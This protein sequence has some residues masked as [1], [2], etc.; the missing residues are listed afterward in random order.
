MNDSKINSDFKRTFLRERS[1]FAFQNPGRDWKTSKRPLGDGI[2]RKH[3]DHKL[4]IGTRAGW[5]V[6]F[7]CLDI[8]TPDK[9]ILDEVCSYF[10]F[11]DMN[12]LI[13]QSPNKGYH[14]LFKPRFNDRVPTQKLYYEC[15]TK[16]EKRLQQLL[17]I[18]QLEIF[19]KSN[20][21]LRGPLGR[22]QIFIDPDSFTPYRLNQEQLMNAFEKL[23]QTDLKELSIQRYIPFDYKEEPRKEE[24]LYNEKATGEYLYNFGPQPGITRYDT[25]WKIILYL[26]R[27]NFN[28]DEIYGKIYQYIIKHQNWFNE[29][30]RHGRQ[31]F[32]RAAAQIKYLRNNEAKYTSYPDFINNAEFYF[33]KSDLVWLLK[34]FNRK[35]EQRAM[36]NLIRYYRPR[37]QRVGSWVRIHH[38]RWIEWTDWRSYKRF[39]RMLE[40]KNILKSRKNYVIGKYARHYKLNLPTVQGEILQDGRQVRNFETALTKTFSRKDLYQLVGKTEK[41]K[42]IIEKASEQTVILNPELLAI[43]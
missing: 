28:Y 5:Y 40:S 10:N 35:N 30:S 6:G 38:H 37:A 41:V 31:V 16:S 32:Q 20:R 34:T 9:G 33:G 2:I 22:D 13:E 15:L 19:P 3:L 39:Q 8:D 27:L 23:N 1:S 18:P 24:V 26:F 17:N 43:C 11:S 4:W 7:G 42:R 14:I 21:A 12:S 36:F 25:T 29:N